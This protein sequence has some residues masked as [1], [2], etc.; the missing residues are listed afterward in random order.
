MNCPFSIALIA[1]LNYTLRQSE[2]GRMK[3]HLS[4]CATCQAQKRV[5]L[6]PPRSSRPD[7]E[8]VD[9]AYDAWKD[10]L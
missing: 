10:E 5:R 7:E 1:Y 3:A 8:A 4:R 6:I 9:R 2:L